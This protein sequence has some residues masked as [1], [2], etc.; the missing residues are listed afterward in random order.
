MNTRFRTFVANR[1]SVVRE[2]TTVTQWKYIGKKLNPA[3]LSSSGMTA[4]TFV[5][6]NQWIHGPEFLWKSN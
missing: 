4:D 1:I 6:C 5:K 3:D 2:K